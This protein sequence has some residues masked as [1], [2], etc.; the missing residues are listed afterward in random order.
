MD[1]TQIIILGLVQ[2]VTEFLP[3][4]ST[5]HLILLPWFFKFPDPG[6]T[7]DIALHLGTLLAILIYFWKEWWEIVQQS[8]EVAHRNFDSA[9]NSLAE[10]QTL[11]N[12]S[13]RRSQGEAS[14]NLWAPR[15][16]SLLFIATIPGIF[17]G[18]LFESWA[19]TFFRSP[20]IIAI[21]LAFFG[22]LLYIAD[23]KFTHQKTLEDLDLKRA[24]FI[25]LG[26]ALAIIPGVSRSG[27]SMTAGLF[28]GLKREAAVK[29]SFLLSAPI[30]AGSVLAGI[31]KISNLESRISN[32]ELFL[33]ILSS[34]AAG[35]LAIKFL[36]KFVQKRSFVPFVIYR[37]IL[38]IIIILVSFI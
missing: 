2:G 34:F 22:L 28:V 7:F 10:N 35:I 16:L 23:K 3:I 33:G 24:F 12:E 30:I 11:L 8:A 4:S 15:A 20:I 36:L 26:Q 9:S 5:A 19:E 38:A 1:F 37:I 17:F 29:F 21:S 31:L 6:L 27:V 32:I 14:Q 25:G 18:F 13:H